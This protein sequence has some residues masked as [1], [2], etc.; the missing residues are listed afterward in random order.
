M[1]FVLLF[2]LT[3]ARAEY[4]LETR[5]G[6]HMTLETFATSRPLGQTIVF[7]ERHAFADDPEEA[8]HANQ[9]RL[10]NALPARQVGMEF[11]E[12]V[13]QPETD[14]LVAGQLTEDEFQTRARWGSSPWAQ[15][16]EQILRGGRTLALNAPR[17][18]TGA[19]ARGLELTDAQRALL[20]PV[21][22]RGGDA[23]FERFRASMGGHGKPEA[24]E[25]Y[26]M[27]HSL[28][29]DTMA[30]NANRGRAQNTVQVLIVGEFHAEYGLGL[31]A[32]LR[33]YGVTDVVTLVQDGPT[34]PDA[35]YG[36]RA[37]YIWVTEEN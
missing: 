13:Y 7:G 37:D 23:Y 32:R 16:R 9:V 8:H 11:I 6:T 1:L 33:R 12:Y 10:L 31:P 27:A 25:R 36:W 18:L 4:I 3:T 2:A 26:F 35:Q 29:D 5:T 21:W 28:W 20:P 15:Y 19:V 22:E 17:E 24:L 14:Q 34:T 30:W